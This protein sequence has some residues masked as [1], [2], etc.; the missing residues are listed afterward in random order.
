MAGIKPQEIKRV[1]H[2]YIGVGATD[3]LDDFTH[4]SFKEFY[5][6]YCELDIDTDSFTGNLREKFE[7]V[8][9]SVSPQDQAKILRGV[10]A[11]CPVTSFKKTRTAAAHDEPLKMADRLEGAMQAPS[12]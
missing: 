10:V 12:L 1:T 6:H 8:L 7:A 2:G 11:K 9:A 4:K 5:P 3:I